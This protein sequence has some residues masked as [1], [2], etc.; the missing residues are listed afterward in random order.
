VDIVTSSGPAPVRDITGYDADEPAP[1]RDVTGYDADEY[2]TYL[3][4]AFWN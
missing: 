1:V 4:L 2:A 3:D